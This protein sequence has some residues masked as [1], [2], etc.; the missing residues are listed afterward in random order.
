MS[1]A[2][3]SS[4]S[5]RRVRRDVADAGR[6][7]GRSTSS[8]WVVADAFCVAVFVATE[9]SVVVGVA[10][11]SVVAEVVAGVDVVAVVDVPKLLPGASRAQS[12]RVT[13]GVSS[14]SSAGAATDDRRLRVRTMV[15][16]AVFKCLLA[17]TSALSASRC[18]SV[19]AATATLCG[20]SG[21]FLDERC[22]FHLVG[23][24]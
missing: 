19:A 1:S 2:L 6:V 10:L 23:V 24:H 8:A 12:T 18:L 21:V 16:A 7:G 15:N 9:S 5:R 3:A 11:V 13:T 17:G 22:L 4:N 20:N 14:V